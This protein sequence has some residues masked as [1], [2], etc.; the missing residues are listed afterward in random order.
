MSEHTTPTPPRRRRGL[1]AAILAVAALA[2]AVPATGALAGGDPG[3]AGAAPSGA[4]PR[5]APV[6]EP[7]GGHH[8]NC[9]GHHGAPSTSSRSSGSNGSAV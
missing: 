8:G 1:I 7:D 2:I 9:P 3:S 5:T 4:Q 6:Q